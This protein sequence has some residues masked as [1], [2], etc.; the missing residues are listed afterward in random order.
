[1]FLCVYFKKVKKCL[2]KVDYFVFKNKQ[3]SH[4]GNVFLLFCVFKKAFACRIF[5]RE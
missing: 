3:I 5:W 4:C 2:R 1:M